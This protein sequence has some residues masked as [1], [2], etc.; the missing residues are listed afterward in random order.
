[1]RRLLLAALL[2][3]LAAAAAVPVAG[4]AGAAGAASSPAGAPLTPSASLADAA[5]APEL[6]PGAPVIPARVRVAGVDVGGLQIDA[7][8]QFVRA[9]FARPLVVVVA[10]RRIAVTPADLGAVAYTGSAVRRALAVSAGGSVDLSVRVPGAGVRAFVERLAATVDKP[11]VNRT[12]KLVD[13][14][15]TLSPGLAGRRL[16]RSTA[17]AAIVRALVTGR[18]APTTLPLRPVK[19]AMPAVAQTDLIVI[20]RASNQLE[21]FRGIKL[22]RRFGVATGRPEYPTP[23]GTFTIVNKQR[24]PW[25]YPPSSDWAK[26][27]KP[28]PPGPGNPLGTRW[29][30]LSEPLVGIHGTP[31][32][33]SIGYS[34]SH[35]CIRMRIDQVEWLFEQVGTGTKVMIVP[36]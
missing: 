17:V 19:P 15:P 11:V 33:A 20:R 26:G 9:S 35:G 21:L 28:V 2:V 3:L 7:A 24:D 8:E 12:L 32:A 30:G 1:M 18:R 22:V 34:R 14:R 36:A 4:A 25:W 13:F 6:V 10:G 31:D 29:M 23:L 5:Y 16:D 27:E